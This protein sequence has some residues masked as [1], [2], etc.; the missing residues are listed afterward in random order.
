[1]RNKALPKLLRAIANSED[2][3]K[4]KHDVIFN[5]AATELEKL[6]M[7]ETVTDSIAASRNNILAIIRDIPM[8][9]IIRK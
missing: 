9:N 3:K 4:N 1:M 5:E 6:D 8:S 2:A 7:I